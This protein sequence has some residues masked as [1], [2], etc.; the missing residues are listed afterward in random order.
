LNFAIA[1]EIEKLK[2]AVEESGHNPEDKTLN[3]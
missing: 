3:N 2:A 1:E